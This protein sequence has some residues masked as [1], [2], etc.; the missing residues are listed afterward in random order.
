MQKCMKKTAATAIS[1]PMTVKNLPFAASF[2]SFLCLM[3]ENF[4]CPDIFFTSFLLF[5]TTNKAALCLSA[6]SFLRML[7]VRTQ[8][9]SSISR[10]KFTVYPHEPVP[11]SAS[12]LLPLPQQTVS[13]TSPYHPRR[14]SRPHRKSP[15]CRSPPQQPSPYRK[16]F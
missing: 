4:E 14:S 10:N 3:F 8:P 5:H 12:A 1:L 6:L 2:F 16:S 9:N 11:R 13:R 15:I 7:F